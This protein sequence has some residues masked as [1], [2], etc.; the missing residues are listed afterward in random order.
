MKKI[1]S[2]FVICLIAVLLH[3]QNQ[4]TATH[5]LH[6]VEVTGVPDAS[7]RGSGVPFQI[8][9]GETLQKLSVLQ[10]SDAL[11]LMSGILV[12]DWGG[13]GGLKTV[14]VRGFGA[15]HT[16]VAYDGLPIIDCQTGQI[17]LG[18][19]SLANTQEISLII[20]NSDNIFVPARML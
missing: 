5:W 1:F 13:A 6:A 3:A 8:L 20:G 16:G 7:N 18:K 10:M 4:D 11:K 12:K 2:A 19:F 9:E 15:Q 17:D 14:S